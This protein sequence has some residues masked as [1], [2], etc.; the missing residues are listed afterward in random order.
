MCF[1]IPVSDMPK[2]SASSLI[3]ALPGPS[4][5]STARRVGSAS[6]A[7]ARSTVGN[8]EPLGSVLHTCAERAQAS[9]LLAARQAMNGISSAGMITIGRIMSRSSCSRMWQWYM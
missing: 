2:G 9:P 4:R 1:F 8:T 7:N 6:A 3:V 5:S